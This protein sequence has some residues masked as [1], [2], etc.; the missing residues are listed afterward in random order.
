MYTG[1]YINL[2]RCP[3][4]RAEIETELARVGLAQKYRRFAAADGN[5]LNLLQPRLNNG[6]MGCFISHYLLLK[7][8]LGTVQHLHV[9]EDDTVF[10]KCFDQVITRI[11]ESG[12][13]DAYD[14]LYTDAS[15]P[16][17]NE[18]YKNFKA[19]YDEIVTRDA[20]GKLKNAAFQILKP[21][22][23]MF[24]NTNSFLVNRKSLEKIYR[25]YE[26][27]LMRGAQAPIDLFLRNAIEAGTI[28]AGC[29]FPFI[30]CARPERS[31]HSLVR[32]VPDVTLKFTAA[33]IA[34]YSFFIDC[35]WKECEAML[36]RLIPVPPEQDRHA[37][38]LSHVLSFSLIS[39]VRKAEQPPKKTAGEKS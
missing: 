2:D 21:D 28:K 22:Q 34:R 18:A 32:K 19:L 4:R 6:E 7:E 17:S 8:N 24:P 1:L 9:L 11:I 15:L 38:I 14:I 3:D 30:T 35:D 31:M 36:Q 16:L 5:T 12:E 25:L 26:E 29:I 20:A 10:A 39:A 23:Q 33:G 37:A 13:I 27:E